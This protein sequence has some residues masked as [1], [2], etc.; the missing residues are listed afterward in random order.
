MQFWVEDLCWCE[1]LTVERIITFMS[2]CSVLSK[3]RV[4][5]KPDR[6]M[7]SKEVV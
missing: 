4:K 7:F 3:Q 6:A 2:L 5:V 1:T